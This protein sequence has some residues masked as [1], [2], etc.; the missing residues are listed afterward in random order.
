[1]RSRS[2]AGRTRA[3][4]RIPPPGSWPTARNRA[5]DRLRRARTLE[6]KARLLEVVDVTEDEREEMTIPDER[7]EL[8]FTCCHPALATDAQVALTL[9]AVGGLATAEIANAFLVAPER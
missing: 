4:P 1:L 8:L 6:E 3:C 2:S 5:I 7:L 9:R